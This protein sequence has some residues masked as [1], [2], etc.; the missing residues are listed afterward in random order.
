M[1]LQRRGSSSSAQVP[2]SNDGSSDEFGE[3][4]VLEWRHDPAGLAHWTE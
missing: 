2:E 3:L 1:L 4:A